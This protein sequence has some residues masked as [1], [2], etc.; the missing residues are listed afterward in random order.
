MFW[1]REYTLNYKFYV[2]YM[3]LQFYSSPRSPDYVHLKN[4]KDFGVLRPHMPFSV[5]GGMRIES[6]QTEIHD[7][8]RYSQRMRRI[9]G[10]KSHKNISYEQKY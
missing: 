5:R 7:N 8:L 4:Q 9:F 1:N 3:L 10:D 6:F 2:L